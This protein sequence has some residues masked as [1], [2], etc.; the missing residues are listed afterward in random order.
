VTT[1]RKTEEQWDS[2]NGWAPLVWISVAGLRRYAQHDLA[3]EIGTRFLGRIE[4]LFATE[5]K[6]VEKYDVQSAAVRGGGG[7]EY[8]LQDGFGWTN[9]V[10]LELLELYGQQTP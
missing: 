4:A 7:G 3:R 2:P 5:A 1:A 10:T 6:L 8:P 9:G